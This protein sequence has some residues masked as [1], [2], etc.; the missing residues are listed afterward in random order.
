[1]DPHHPHAA[2]DR[3]AF[4]VFAGLVGGGAAALVATALLNPPRA[5]APPH[6]APAA[7][8]AAAAAG[9]H[10]AGSPGTPA[11]PAPAP[12]AAPAVPPVAA[13]L[14]WS[15][16]LGEA[17]VQWVESGT[18]DL[19]L[20]GGGTARVV[21]WE[22]AAPWRWAA[23]D[24][25]RLGA[26]PQELGALF[27]DEYLRERLAAWPLLVAVG[28]SAG[29]GAGLSEARATALATALHTAVP[30]ASVRALDVGDFAGGAEV[31]RPL[32]LVGLARLDGGPVSDEALLSLCHDPALGPLLGSYG[33]EPFA[34]YG[35]PRLLARNPPGSD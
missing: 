24:A 27:T 2:R 13:A 31:N 25:A 6:G 11:P 22:A 3:T 16:P 1:M 32:R 29:E 21:V 14:N 9:P 18:A 7:A 5:H 34:G 33:G 10:G 23:G 28:L 35:A 26:P 15:A 19:A 20:A 30:A 4:A 8:D 12:E 17:S